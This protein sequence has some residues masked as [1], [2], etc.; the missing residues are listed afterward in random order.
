M[1]S[2]TRTLS[3]RIAAEIER[4]LDFLATTLRDFPER[5]RS[6]Q[7]VFAHSWEMLAEDERA[8]FRRLAVF[9]GGFLREAAGQAG[10]SLR[11]LSALVDKSF[12]R[13]DGAGRYDI[14]E[15]LRQYGEAQLAAA[16]EVDAVRDAHSAY[17]LRFVAELEADIKGRNQKGA[18]N[19]IEAEFENVRAA[20][21]R[22][23][24]RFDED[25]INAAL[26]GLYR[27]CD[28]RC[29]HRFRDYA[30]TPRSG[31]RRSPASNPGWS[32][33]G[34]SRGGRITAYPDGF[35]VTAIRRARCCLS[36]RWR[37]RRPTKTR[38]KSPFAVG[39]SA[40]RS[41]GLKR[42]HAF[43]KPS[44]SLRQVGRSI[45]S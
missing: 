36:A 20:W 27:F 40:K 14:Q 38:G 21:Y 35:R 24:D 9:R 10:A 30:C 45:V 22:A 19:E 34:V 28:M 2:W 43:P 23:V 26:E 5:H 32:G 16:G 7:A 1:A 29:H 12:V 8:V 25:G 4:G 3:C 41:C 33:G 11:T 6:M 17:Y 39:D 15:L 13:V 18:L 37:R 44:G 31:S 42:P